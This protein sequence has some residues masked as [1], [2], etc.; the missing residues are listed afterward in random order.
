MRKR[1]TPPDPT[2]CKGNGAVAGAAAERLC[3]PMR[4]GAAAGRRSKVFQASHCGQRPSHR[5]DSKP[6]AE[7]K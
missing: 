5:G 1:E 6:Q 3:A 2:W 4:A 7:Q